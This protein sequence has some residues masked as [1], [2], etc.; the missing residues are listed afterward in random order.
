[1]VREWDRHHIGHRHSATEDPDDP[2]ESCLLY[3]GHEADMTSS[4][5]RSLLT[6]DRPGTASH[7]QRTLAT[8]DEQVRRIMFDE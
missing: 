2:E 3:R 1:M 4:S 6:D 7:C 5:L 8:S